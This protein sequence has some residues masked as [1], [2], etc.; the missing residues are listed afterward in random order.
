MVH[1][2]RALDHGSWAMTISPLHGADPFRKRL[3]CAPPVGHRSGHAAKIDVARS[4][5]HFDSIA[6]AAGIR[7]PIH[8]LKTGFKN[9]QHQAV[10]VMVIVTVLV[11]TIDEP[12]PKFLVTRKVGIHGQNEVL[13]TDRTGKSTRKRTVTDAPSRNFRCLELALVKTH[14]PH[15]TQAIG[16][17]PK[18]DHL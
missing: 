13:E 11:R 17:A 9:L 18:S 15:C 12:E 3:T 10:G 8:L 4:R 16:Y 6:A 5:Q 2:C 7:A 14:L 1:F